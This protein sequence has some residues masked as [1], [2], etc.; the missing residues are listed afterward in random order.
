M[1]FTYDDEVDVLY[2]FL[3]EGATIEGSIVVDDDRTVDLDSRGRP[4]GIEVLGASERVA[5][6]DI[7]GQFELQDRWEALS[8]IEETPFR[9]A[10]RA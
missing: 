1:R 2:V 4:I 5:L 3:R 10:V 7:A 6:S 8:A 9:R